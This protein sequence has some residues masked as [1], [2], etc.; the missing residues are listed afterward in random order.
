VDAKVERLSEVLRGVELFSKFGDRSLRELAQLAQERQ[1]GPETVL[2]QE[3]G[4]GNS[5][6]VFLKGSAR[7]ER[8]GA[9]VAHIPEGSYVGEMAL[10]DGK[11]RSATVITDGDAELILLS[12]PLFDHFIESEPALRNAIILELVERVRRVLPGPLD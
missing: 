4:E 11:P 3:G 5:L 10:L 6:T 7:V 1:V 12:K 8:S 2:M 9:T